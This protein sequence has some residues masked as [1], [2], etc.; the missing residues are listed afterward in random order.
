MLH[1]SAINTRIT[2]PKEFTT[3]VGN[4][5]TSKQLL[6]KITFHH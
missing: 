2:P 5:S 3:E 6:A 4:V 1:N